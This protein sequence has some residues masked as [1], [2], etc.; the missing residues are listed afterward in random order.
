MVSLSL[1][2]NEV[3]IIEYRDIYYYDKYQYRIRFHLEGVGYTY[4][5][6]TQQEFLDLLEP[7]STIAAWK[8]VRPKD[9]DKVLNNL[10]NL[11]LFLD[12]RQNVKKTKTSCIRVEGNNVS[13][14]SNDIEELKSTASKFSGVSC[15]LSKAETSGFEGI[16][17]FKNNPPHKFRIYLKT[18]RYTDEEK[19][20]LG[21]LLRKSNMLFPSPAL[22]KWLTLDK[23]WMNAYKWSS[24]SYFIEYDD[25][26]SLTYL[27]LMSGKIF[28]KKYKLER[29]ET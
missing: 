10:S 7:K 11:L 14:F 5:S 4:W 6:K 25:E 21:N 27:I 8:K 3:D 22:Y 13:I 1:I 29:R 2:D 26:S 15:E 20:N 16:K 9:K 28:G 23:V 24:S 12:I 17:F 18:K 19:N